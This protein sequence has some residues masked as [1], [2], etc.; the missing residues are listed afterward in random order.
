MS[1]TISR[2][3]QLGRLVRFPLFFGF[4]TS[5]LSP[6]PAPLLQSCIL[7]FLWWVTL[8]Y[9]TEKPEKSTAD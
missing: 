2:A 5:P 9:G 3:K 6:H 7:L 1:A 8:F 4:F